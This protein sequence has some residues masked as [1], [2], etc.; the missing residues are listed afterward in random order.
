MTM[1]VKL[2]GK[3]ANAEIVVIGEGNSYS[4]PANELVPDWS[5]GYDEEM[6]AIEAYTTGRLKIVDDPEGK[7]FGLNGHA[8]Y[9]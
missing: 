9:E 3:G 4:I 2:I 6:S 7:T 8:Y 1:N 5:G